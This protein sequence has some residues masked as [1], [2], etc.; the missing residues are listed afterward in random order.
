MCFLDRVYK[1]LIISTIV[2]TKRQ[3]L[4]I[5]IYKT[6]VISTIVDPVLSA[7]LLLVYKT[8]VIWLI[9]ENIVPLHYKFLSNSQ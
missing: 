2:D 7:P 1:T 5:V 9:G 6:F 3:L 8:F 4:N